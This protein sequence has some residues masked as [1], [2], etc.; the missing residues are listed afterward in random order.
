MND[1]VEIWY[2]DDNKLCNQKVERSF[3][4]YYMKT[5]TSIDQTIGVIRQLPIRYISH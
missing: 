3:F 5:F 1:I 2:Y 4:Y